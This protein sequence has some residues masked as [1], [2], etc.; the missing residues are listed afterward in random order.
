MAGRF[1]VHQAFHCPLYFLQ[2]WRLSQPSASWCRLP[3]YR[4]FGDIRVKGEG[5]GVEEDAE[6]TRPSLEDVLLVSE[7]YSILVLGERL[8]PSLP[9]AEAH[10]SLEVF[11]H[12]PHVAVGVY[13]FEFRH[14][15]LQMGINARVDCCLHRPARCLKGPPCC[16]GPAALEGAARFPPLGHGLL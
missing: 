4:L 16:R 5:L 14:V 7:Q 8:S 1:P 13:R 3:L 12:P 10:R 15:P 6:E 2:G 9:P 11:V